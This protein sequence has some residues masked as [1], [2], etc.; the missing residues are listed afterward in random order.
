MTELA[1]EHGT[2]VENLLLP[3][4][5]RRLCW[6]PPDDRGVESVASRLRERGAREWQVQLTAEPLSKALQAD[7]E[8]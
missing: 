2:P 8:S 1:E 4:L 5:L 6:S 3:D 7:A